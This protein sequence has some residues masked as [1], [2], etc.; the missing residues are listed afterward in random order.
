MVDDPQLE[1]YTACGGKIIQPERYISGEHNGETV[2][3]CSAACYQV[4]LKDPDRFM[5]GEIEHPE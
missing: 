3:F 1:S 4:F 2:Y 5:A